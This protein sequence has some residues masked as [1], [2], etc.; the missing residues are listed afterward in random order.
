M[1]DCFLTVIISD[2]FGKPRGYTTGSTTTKTSPLETPSG[3]LNY[4]NPQSS[5]I[6][7]CQSDALSFCCWACR[8]T[9]PQLLHIEINIHTFIPGVCVPSSHP[10]LSKNLEKVSPML[11]PWGRDLSTSP[12]A[13]ERSL[14]QPTTLCIHLACLCV[15]GC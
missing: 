4:N 12:N 8:S 14:F 15:Y 10:S 3:H 7:F 6:S 13:N 5:V 11:R 2:A 9:E 1:F